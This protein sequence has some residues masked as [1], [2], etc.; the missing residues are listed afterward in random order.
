MTNHWDQ[1]DWM[2]N[3]AVSNDAFNLLCNALRPTALVVARV[4]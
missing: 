3:M 2:K 1:K 4:V